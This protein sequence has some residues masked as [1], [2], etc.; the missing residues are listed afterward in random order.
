MLFHALP[1][2]E[3]P[4]HLL[5]LVDSF[6]NF[7]NYLR[8]YLHQVVFPHPMQSRLSQESL[9]F[10]LLTAYVLITLSTLHCHFGFINLS[11]PLDCD[12]IRQRLCLLSQHI[13]RLV[14]CP[15]H[16]KCAMNKQQI[17]K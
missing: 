2:P 9:L 6:L 4:S 11:S 13:Q 17:N 12:V 1:L 16:R 15:P 3:Y 10:H 8:L 14:P 7:K 5:Y